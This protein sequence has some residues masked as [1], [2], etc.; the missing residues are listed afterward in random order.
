MSESPKRPGV[1]RRIAMRIAS[2]PTLFRRIGLIRVGERIVAALTG[3]RRS[4][5]DVATIDNL[6]LTVVGR[7]TGTPYRF[8]LACAP[9]GDGW[10]IAASNFG[11]DREPQWAKNLRATDLAAVTVRGRE[12]PVTVRQPSAE[13]R[14]AVWSA[15]VASWPLF[16]T[17]QTRTRRTIAVFVLT[18]GASPAPD[19]HPTPGA[20]NAPR[21]RAHERPATA[22]RDS[23]DRGAEE[24][25]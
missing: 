4:L 25:V 24:G 15:L 19:T 16:A 17:Y 14:P 5:L 22:E 8:E 21:D 23:G 18:P 13:E 10:A 6:G 2:T 20:R 7:R 11:Q 9:Y 1:M 12:I 3:G